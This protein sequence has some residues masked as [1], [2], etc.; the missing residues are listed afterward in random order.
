MS[1][2]RRKKNVVW[3]IECNR[4]L[5]WLPS[6]AAWE[7]TMRRTLFTLACWLVV[8]PIAAR[9][10]VSAAVSETVRPNILIILADDVA[11]CDDLI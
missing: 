8:T 3:E 6:L 9:K 4:S 7:N 1:A 2:R 11:A 5:L 10:D